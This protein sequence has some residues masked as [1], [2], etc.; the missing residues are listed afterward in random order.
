MIK[1]I[2]PLK[3]S[4]IRTVNP[5]FFPN[6]RKVFAAPGLPLPKS[7]ISID[8]S[9]FPAIYDDGIDPAI[10]ETEITSKIMF[11]PPDLFW[12]ALVSEYLSVFY[13]AQNLDHSPIF[14]SMIFQEAV[15]RSHKEAV[16]L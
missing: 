4:K 13:T 6:T 8:L 12:E 11:N 7:L 3:K 1:G 9:N 15:S 14:H 5:A 16:K 10:Y 2:N